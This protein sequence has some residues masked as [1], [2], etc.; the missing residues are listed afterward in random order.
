MSQE[1]LNMAKVKFE[2]ENSSDKEVSPTKATFSLMD[3]Q[4]L[5]FP[6]RTVGSL[7]LFVLLLYGYI[8]LKCAHVYMYAV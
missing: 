1:M 7:L 5:D 4:S 6:D 3:A 8:R 2:V